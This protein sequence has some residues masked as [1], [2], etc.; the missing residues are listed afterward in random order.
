MNKLLLKM[1]RIRHCNTI[2]AEVGK[3]TRFCNAATNDQ[4]F[5]LV[6]PITSYKSSESIL[7]KTLSPLKKQ[8]QKRTKL[9]KS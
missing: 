2:Y 3:V 9:Q 4:L 5:F 1:I 8:T 6:K 7:V